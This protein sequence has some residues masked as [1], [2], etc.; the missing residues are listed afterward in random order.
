PGETD[1]LGNIFAFGAM[2]SFT[3]AHVSVIA[4]RLSTRDDPEAFK[5]RP[6]LR[7]G[8]VDWP[9]FAIFGALG[10][11]I[12]WIV[13]VI[14]KPGPR[15]AGLGWLVVGLIGYVVYRR[16]VIREPVTATLRAP[17]I[18]GPGAALEYR[19]ILVPV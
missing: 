6:S 2:L 16:R 9:L 15:W 3:I 17:V 11:G 13:V 7:I 14:Q 10:T 18:I 12:A 8:G 19:R 1:F 4:L 5:V